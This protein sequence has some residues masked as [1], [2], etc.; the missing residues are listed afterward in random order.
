MEEKTELR[1]YSLVL[2]SLMPIQKGIQTQHTTAEYTL[3]FNFD[4]V[5][6]EWAKNHKTTIVLDGGTSN[7][8]NES[9]YGY[10][11]Q[12]GGLELLVDEFERIGIRYSVFYEPGVNYSLTSIGMILPEQVFNTKKYPGFKTWLQK[13]Y[14][15][16]YRSFMYTSPMKAEYDDWLDTLSNDYMT[17]I[18]VDEMRKLVNHL[19]LAR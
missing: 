15:R 12:K 2:Y 13:R 16:E 11:K 6:V 19:P 17:T 10:P 3:K 8:G 18:Q 9:H 1:F 14:G 4:D 5:Y 7:S